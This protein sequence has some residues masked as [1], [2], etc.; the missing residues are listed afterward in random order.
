MPP[1]RS[2][3][4]MAWTRALTLRLHVGRSGSD[5]L[6]PSPEPAQ[7]KRSA[8]PS[9]A[10]VVICSRSPR[11]GLWENHH[12]WIRT[13]SRS[14]NAAPVVAPLAMGRGLPVIWLCRADQIDAAHL[15]TRQYNH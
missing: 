2:R 3:A 14:E 8:E 6:L 15:D 4:A 10:R 9:L 13:A 5:G 7:S 11:T 12:D 1:N